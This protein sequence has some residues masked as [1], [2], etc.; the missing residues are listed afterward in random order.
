VEL[1]VEFEKEEYGRRI[2]PLLEL[3]SQMN[4]WVAAGTAFDVYLGDRL[5]AGTYI[6]RRG[7]RWSTC[8]GFYLPPEETDRRCV[9]CCSDPACCDQDE[10]GDQ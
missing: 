9:R 6:T 7:L 10:E 3:R 5:V 4:G 2:I 8:R 1:L